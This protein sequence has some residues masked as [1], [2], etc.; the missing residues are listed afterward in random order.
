MRRTCRSP[1]CPDAAGL[2][3][4]GIHTHRQLLHQLNPVSFY[5]CSTLLCTSSVMEDGWP[6]YCFNTGCLSGRYQASNIKRYQDYMPSLHYTVA[7]TCPII[8]RL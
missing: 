5:R 8:F 7:A 2:V 4:E 3:F 1:H 6:S